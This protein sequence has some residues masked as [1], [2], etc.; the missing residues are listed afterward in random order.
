MENS[1]PEKP[2]PPELAG[3]GLQPGRSALPPD[4]QARLLN[5][6]DAVEHAL[7]AVGKATSMADLEAV[8]FT[9]K[10]ASYRLDL[11]RACIAADWPGTERALEAIRKL[12]A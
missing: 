1:Q 12:T 4:F 9:H 7:D 2:L 10:M 11:L 6:V 5:V 8:A 3:A